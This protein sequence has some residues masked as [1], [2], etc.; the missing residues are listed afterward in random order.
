[1]PAIK[2]W[3]NRWMTRIINFITKKQFTDVSCGFRAY[4]RD[5]ALRLTL[6]GRFTYTQETLIDLAFKDIDMVEVPL[7]IRGERQHGRS[8][9]ASNLWRYAVKSATIIF[10][11]ARDYRPFY[12]FGA[13]GLVLLAAGILAGLFLLAHYFNT[14][15]TY[16]FRSLVQLSSVLIIVG[17][18]LLFQSIL[19]DMMHR[20]RII[21]EE[22]LYLARKVA[23]K[24]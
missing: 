8:R 17:I 20:A 14:G 7:K 2:L 3:G 12:F 4:S 24:K 6:F 10:R 23:Y 11:A 22:A 5:A 1:M 15:Q 9:V 21:N 19:A 16:P 18:I 13:P